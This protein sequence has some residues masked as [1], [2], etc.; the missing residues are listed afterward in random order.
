LIDKRKIE[1]IEIVRVEERQVPRSQEVYASGPFWKAT[2]AFRDA[3]GVVMQATW[4][5]PVSE[6][7]DD[8]VVPVVR[9]YLHRL[10]KDIA[11]QTPDWLLDDA[12]YQAMKRQVPPSQ[13][14]GPSKIP[15]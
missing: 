13:S 10:C 9:N 14:K 11:D 15:T 4:Y 1:I 8:S 12:K 7:A 5:L 3:I 2:I 6:F